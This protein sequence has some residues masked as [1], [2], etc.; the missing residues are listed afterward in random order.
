MRHTVGYRL[1]L[2]ICLSS[3]KKERRLSLYHIFIDVVVLT[4]NNSLYC[5]MPTIHYSH[6]Y[7]LFL[8]W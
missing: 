2:D 5:L 7:R 4:I 3:S 8:Y 6:W 1:R